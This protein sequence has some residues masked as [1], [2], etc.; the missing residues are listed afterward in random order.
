MQRI[1]IIIVMR[2][3]EVLGYGE[4]ASINLDGIKEGFNQKEQN[5]SWW[6]YKLSDEVLKE[7]GFDADHR[8]DHC[9]ERY[10]KDDKSL[11]EKG[12]CYE[13]E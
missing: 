9:L 8:C 1:I 10:G 5:L 11:I 13:L 7:E 6:F 2:C 12:F 4:L 3:L